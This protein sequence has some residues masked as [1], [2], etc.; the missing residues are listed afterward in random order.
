MVKLSTRVNAASCAWFL[1]GS[2]RPDA[3]DSRR[4][5]AGFPI[6]PLLSLRRLWPNGRR[7]GAIVGYGHQQ[8]AL[9][10]D[11]HASAA[12]EAAHPPSSPWRLFPPSVLPCES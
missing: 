7:G 4:G 6:R 5:T 2:G 1:G 8:V 9:Q 12:L 10:E 11:G 3:D